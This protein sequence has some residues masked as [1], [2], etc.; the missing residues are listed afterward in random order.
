MKSVELAFLSPM[1]FENEEPKTH[2]HA[3]G[4]HHVGSHDPAPFIAL[5]VILLVT[6]LFFSLQPKKKI[7]S[8]KVKNTMKFRRW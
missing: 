3:A 8:K 5:I 1:T 2:A 4:I 7:K 6:V